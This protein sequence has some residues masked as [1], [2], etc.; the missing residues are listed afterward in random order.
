MYTT[1]QYN[2]TQTALIFVLTVISEELD[3]LRFQMQQYGYC[4][5]NYRD[6]S[7]Q[8]KLNKLLE[9]PFNI[10]LWYYTVSGSV[11]FKVGICQFE[12]THESPALARSSVQNGCASTNIT[13]ER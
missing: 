10:R 13:Q 8:M 11:I 9:Y 5:K 2:K 1:L 7:G 6:G 4:G 3:R 12:Y